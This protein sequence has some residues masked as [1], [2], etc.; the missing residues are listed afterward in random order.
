MRGIRRRALGS[1]FRSGTGV[2]AWH[3][4]TLSIPPTLRLSVTRSLHCFALSSP[5]PLNELTDGHSSVLHFRFS[6]IFIFL[7]HFGGG[8]EHLSARL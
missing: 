3:S 2:P 6:F 5:L 7:F 8:D 4:W 1:L